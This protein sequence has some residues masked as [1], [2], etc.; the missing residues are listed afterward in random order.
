MRG[1]EAAP[2]FRQVQFAFDVFDQPHVG[3]FRDTIERDEDIVRLHVAVNQALFVR[4]ME[5]IA[6]LADDVNRGR[7]GDGPRPFDA[8]AERFAVDEFHHQERRSARAAI[9][10]RFHDIRMVEQAG[11][12]E[13]LLESL[14]KHRVLGRFRRDDLNRDDVA[15]DHTARFVDGT[16]TALGNLCQK[17]VV[18]DLS[19]LCGGV[20]CHGRTMALTGEGCRWAWVLARSS[21]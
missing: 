5:A 4:A 2:R 6:D 14:Q 1:A 13:F 16:H 18:A 7:F 21:K 19:R 17:V 20:R 12:A 3:E 11:G 9:L 10:D 8:L 15:R